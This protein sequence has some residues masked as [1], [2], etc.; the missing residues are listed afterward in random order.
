MKNKFTLIEL[1]VVIAIIAILAAMLLPSL[2][3]A[4]DSAQ[5]SICAGNLK[6]CGSDL[7]MYSE[8]FYGIIMIQNKSEGW[9]GWAN[10]ITTPPP[11]D[12]YHRT[13]M[14]YIKYDSP[15]LCCPI[16]PRE[17]SWQRR[18][19]GM[20]CNL[21]ES[22]APGYPMELDPG[23][24]TTCTKYRFL[25]KIRMPAKYFMIADS[26]IPFYGVQSVWTYDRAGTGQYDYGV[27]L[28]HFKSA[29]CIFW[30]GHVDSVNREEFNR[31]NYTNGYYGGIGGTPLVMY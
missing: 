8:D 25:K 21:G 7:F 6:Q 12:T 11:G 1:L 3:K 23:Y 19:Y 4:R 27:H 10:Y 26:A 9:A 31:Q 24:P 17:S 29:N 20:D 2:K 18:T 5:Q 13:R 16:Y 30:D 15:S 22:S 28:R 14:G